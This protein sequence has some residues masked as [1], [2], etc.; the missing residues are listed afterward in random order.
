MKNS[1]LAT[2][3][4]LSPNNSG[5]RKNDI[6][7]ITPHCV[8]GQMS[9]AALGAW[10]AKST[11]QASSNYGIGCDGKIALY[12]DEDN[13]SW[14]SS[15][16]DNDNRAITIE[17]ASDTAS[18]YRMNNCVYN[19]LVEL[20]TDI[21]RRYGKNKLIWIPDKT[22]ALAYKPK[23]NEMLLTVHRWFADKSCPG[24]WLYNRLDGL[25][26]TVTKKLN[27]VYFVQIGSFKKKSN[28]ERL[29]KT[30]AQRDITAMVKHIGDYYVVRT[31]SFKKKKAAE[32]MLKVLK[33][34]G[35]TGIIIEG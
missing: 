35:C 6:T 22:R 14:C 8:V 30:L 18:P 16:A 9:V 31:K 15:N 17:C 1:K 33:A 29:V 12:V 26:E 4:K 11:T 5:K 23:S 3:T 21:C 25:A 19:S 27:P 34:N 2:Y 24:N 20:C 10:F 7:R 13:R 32:D 28:A